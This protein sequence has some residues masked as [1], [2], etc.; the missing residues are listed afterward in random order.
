MTK[1]VLL[2]TYYWPPSGG[3][4]VQRPLKTAKYLSDFGWQPTVYTVSNGEFPELDESLTKDIPASLI[5]LKR[6]ILEPFG[7]Y[8]WFTGKRKEYKLVAGYLHQKKAGTWREKLALW[9]RSN[10][11]VPDAR[12]WW[13]GP[14][15]RYLKKYC[16]THH[17]QAIITTGPPHSVHRIGL[18][19]KLSLGLPWLADFRDPWTQID[20][21]TDLR[22]T[23]YAHKKHLRME[24]E[25]LTCADRVVC[26]S[27]TWGKGLEQLGGRPVDI[28]PNGYDL[29]D[30]PQAQA[31]LDKQFS[32]VHIGMMGKSRNHDCFW[33]AIRS[34]IDEN[35]EF[36]EYLQIKL[37]GKLDESVMLSV[38]QH[39]L[40]NWV[41]HIPYVPHK[42]II[43]IQQQ[44]RVLYLSVNQTANAIGIVT[45][46][47]Y[48]YLASRRPILCIGPLHG[49]A[50]QVLKETGAGVTSDFDD[51]AGLKTN[52]QLLFQR[53]LQGQDVQSHADISM[54]SRK[55][56][57]GQ[58]AQL[59]DAMILNQA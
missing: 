14:S 33:K 34:V 11:F 4:G 44:S 42:D 27:R 2:L 15:Y 1:K 24:K 37:Y 43:Q 25:V 10:Y 40:Q 17:I 53:F 16:R 52:L 18:K 29:S 59:L 28:I 36:S 32:I 22:L 55:Y 8:K 31:V 23:P 39:Q 13:I 35:Q 7:L 41:S 19:L 6:P 51:V 26:V 20:Y 58:F 38:Q 12:M 48:E 49:E 57:A 21:W 46:K 30:L 45:G 54:Y 9:L 47:I 5:V 50:A 56:Q 3:S